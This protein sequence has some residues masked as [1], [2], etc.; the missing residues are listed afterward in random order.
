MTEIFAPFLSVL[1][2]AIFIDFLL[3]GGDATAGV[4]RAIGSIFHGQPKTI[5]KE[6]KDG[7]MDMI[8]D[9]KDEIDDLYDDLSYT[10][11]DDEKTIIV[12]R[13]DTKKEILNSL[14]NG[15]QESA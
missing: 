9:L 6:Y 3:N 15:K 11:N 7:R 2:G 10:D 5:T 13:I 8:K 4:F 1:A 12:K 14:L